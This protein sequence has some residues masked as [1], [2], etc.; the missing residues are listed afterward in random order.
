MKTLTI[1]L[2][3]SL[4]AS[5]AAE[6]ASCRRTKSGIIRQLIETSLTP[7]ANGK[8]TAAR[9]SLHERLKKYQTAGP[10]GIRDLASNPGH[11]SGYG[12]R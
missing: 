7:R 9:P 4:D 11:L 3:D 12:R 1:Q 6:A 5:L 2:P 10:T 8:R